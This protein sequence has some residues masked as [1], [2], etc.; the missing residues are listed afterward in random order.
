MLFSTWLAL[1]D[2]PNISAPEQ[3]L[4]NKNLSINETVWVVTVVC[5]LY[6]FGK[7]TKRSS[8]GCTKSISF[9]ILYNS[10]KRVWIT[11]EG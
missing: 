3:V 1:N 11:N 9:K 4:L 8:C 10:L 5:L 2:Q 6:S 7:K